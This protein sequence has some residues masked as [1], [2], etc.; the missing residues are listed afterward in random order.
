MRFIDLVRINV[1]AGRGGNGCLSFRREKYIP[2]GGPDGADGG[3][4]GDILIKAVPGL[5]TL[6]DFE[7]NKRFAAQHGEHGK[8]K[9]QIGAR[10]KDLIIKVPYGT[11]IRDADTNQVLADLVE[12][13]DQVLVAKGG[14]GGRG[15]THFANS[16][17]RTPRF[18]EKGEEG[19]EKSLIMELK[20]IADVGLV[21]LPNAGKSSILGA[22]SNAQPKIAGYPFT[23]LS[24]NL[25]ILSVDDDRIVVADVPG[26]I[27]GASN[28]KGLGIYFLRHIER[29]RVLIHVLDLSSGSAQSV[30]HQ[31]KTIL[32][33]FEAYNKS[34][35]DRPYIVVG[36]KVDITGTKRVSS[37]VHK[38][39]A[40]KNIPYIETSAVSGEGIQ[41]LI[42]KI[43][44]I[45]RQYPRPIGTARI[46]AV[47]T[48]CARDKRAEKFTPVQ[49]LPLSDNSGYKIVHPYLE[50]VITR[51]DFD[52]DEAMFR[53][54]RLLKKFKIEE[55]LEQS[56]AKS[57]DN[58]YIGDMV[59]EFEPDKVME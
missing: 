26:L 54:A 11:I 8:G 40:E 24:P 38:H 35:M 48:L 7:Y 20:L 12:P 22:I 53:F 2:K 5:H 13:G 28:N 29:T 6:A 10:G 18:A 17:R 19:E 23:T 45:V 43:L 34:L 57:G 37:I 16:V 58:V 14:R 41:K 44:E 31:W 49:I 39:M 59:F 4:G 32:G 30:L 36:N 52:Q 42:Q 56:G 33:E 25:G 27:E 15:N 3:D 50:K 1:K 55:L 9:K 47:H 46:A 51:Y 21:G